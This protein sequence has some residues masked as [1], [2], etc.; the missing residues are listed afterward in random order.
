[1]FLRYVSEL[2]S[3]RTRD[4]SLGAALKRINVELY[5]ELRIISAVARLLFSQSN[6]IL[7][8]V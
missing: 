1:M 6:D 7:S 2:N 5:P 4:T 3:K 8:S